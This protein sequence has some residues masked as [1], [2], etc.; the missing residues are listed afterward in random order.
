ML[1]RLSAVGAVRRVLW[2]HDH[3]GVVQRIA[4]AGQRFAQE[5]LSDRC[6]GRALRLVLME[7]AKH[8]AARG[9][10]TRTEWACPADC[11]HDPAF[12]RV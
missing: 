7:L 11:V 9:L 4:H 6:A 10:A 5:Q 2:A 1:M 12:V 8:E 3:D